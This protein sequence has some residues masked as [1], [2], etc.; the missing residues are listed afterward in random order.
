MKQ[1]IL[2][3]LLSLTVLQAGALAASSIHT[4]THRAKGAGWTFAYQYPQL[5]KAGVEVDR[6]I[7]ADLAVREPETFNA[8]V[9]RAKAAL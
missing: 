3:T 8:L 6:K 1:P 5:G 2:I 9:D 4:Q 7:L